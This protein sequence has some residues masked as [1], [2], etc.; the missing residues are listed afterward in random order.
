MNVANQAIQDD[1]KGIVLIFDE[2]GR[3]VEDYGEVLKVKTIQDL[4]EYC[5]HSDY[6]NYLILVSHPQYISLL[7]E[8]RE[9]P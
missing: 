7:N 9:K 2:F 3:Y 4:A 8:V 5:D 6:D 1:Y